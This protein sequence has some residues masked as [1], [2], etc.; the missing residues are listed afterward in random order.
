M[1]KKFAP[2]AVA[3]KSAL[4]TRLT[5][6]IAR[7]HK[8]DFDAI[9]KDV[10]S[11]NYD[12]KR[13]ELE[14]AIKLACDGKLAKDADI[15]DLADLL[16]AFKGQAENADAMVMEPNAAVM[17]MK[18]K[19]GEDAES[20][21]M[22]AKIKAYLEE[23]GVSPEIIANLDSFAAEQGDPDP[24]LGDPGAGDE[25]M[26]DEKRD[27]S[28]KTAEDDVVPKDQKNL[29]TQTAM[30]AAIKRHVSA[31]IANQKAIRKAERFVFPWVGELAMDAA[32]PADVYR[33]ALKGLNMDAKRVDD[34]HPDA[35][36]PVLEAQPRPSARISNTP[37]IA[38]D[39]KPEKSFA[40]RF[41]EANDIRM[42]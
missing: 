21:D 2:A 17:P 34:M 14:K 36:R 7:D 12:A 25:D 3:L 28:K 1:P 8:I 37:R 29:V 42:Q 15:G 19:D 40:E 10:T 9:V 31:T 11:K 6:V 13:P 38:S 22:I 35:L 30:D 41:P 24:D 5:P 20:P 33:A 26:D 18:P 4:F 16:D 27:E 23:E 39:A 32:A